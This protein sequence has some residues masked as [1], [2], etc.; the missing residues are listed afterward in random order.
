MA[1]KV[2]KRGIPPTQWVYHGVCERCASE[3]EATAEDLELDDPKET[4][5][6]V[7]YDCPVCE[8]ANAMTFSFHSKGPQQ[9]EQKPNNICPSCNG[10][11]PPCNVCNGTGIKS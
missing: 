2:T 9:L 3:A 6:D 10:Y 7:E 1:I 8:S 11:G 4:D 5:N